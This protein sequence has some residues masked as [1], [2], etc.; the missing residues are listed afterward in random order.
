MLKNTQDRINFGV[1]YYTEPDE[2]GHQYGP[3]S[4]DVKKILNKLDM[5]VGYLMKQLIKYDLFD[6]MSR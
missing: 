6:K 4:D 1:L 5:V 2:T 3:Y